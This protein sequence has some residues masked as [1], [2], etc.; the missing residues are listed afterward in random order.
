MANMVAEACAEDLERWLREGRDD[1]LQAH[2]DARWMGGHFIS[3]ATGMTIRHCPFLDLHE[4]SFVCTIYKTRPRAC[5]TFDPASSEIC[6]QF[7]KQAGR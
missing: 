7:G 2:H 5:R 6:P 3:V 1:I 4:R